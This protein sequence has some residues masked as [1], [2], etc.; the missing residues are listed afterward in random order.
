MS[1]LTTRLPRI[2]VALTLIAIAAPRISAASEQELTK[3]YKKALALRAKKKL[4]EA[5]RVCEK[6]L[7]V[8][9]KL[10]GSRHKDTAVVMYLLGMI[11]YEQ[12]E[13]D[14]AETIFKSTL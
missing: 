7:V 2:V 1:L 10:F 3:L 9:K 14:R 8:A 11:Y 4:P 6:A 12:G 13:Y 5:G